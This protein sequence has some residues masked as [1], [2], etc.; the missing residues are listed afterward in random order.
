MCGIAGYVS[1][2]D[3]G[4]ASSWLANAQKA[5][6]HRGPDG[7]AFAFLKE[8]GFVTSN[9]TTERTKVAL[10]HN[11]LSIID[12]SDGGIQ[13]KV[14]QCGR[15]AMTFNGEIY[16][17]RELRRQLEADFGIQM[18]TESDSEVLIEG[19]SAWGCQVLTKLVGMFVF[20][21]VDRLKN[22][23]ILVR[24]LVGIKPL[25]YVET[26]A[27]LAFASE[28]QCLLNWPGVTT[29][30]DPQSTVDYLRFGFSDHRDCK[31]FKDIR[32]VRPGTVETFSLAQG[33]K[34]KSEE[35]WSAKPR[36]ESELSFEDARNRLRELLLESVDYHLR[37][38]VPVA[39]CLSGGIDSSSLVMMMRH[40]G[41][42]SAE[43]HTFSHIAPGTAFDEQRWMDPVQ[44]ASGAIAHKIET[45]ADDLIADLP[46]LIRIQQQPFSTT[47]IYAQ[48]RVM[49]SLHESGLKV[50]LD[51]QGADELFGGYGFHIGARI[52]SLIRGSRFG[53]ALNLARAGGELPGMTF[54]GQ[55][56][57]ALDYV[58]NPQLQIW[59]RRVAGKDLVPSWLNETWIKDN[60]VRVHPY[61]ESRSKF[62]LKSALERGMRGPGLPHLLRYEDQNSMAHSIESRVPYLS[63]PVMEFVLSLPEKYLIS[64][65]AVTKP[66]LREAMRGL[67]PDVVLDRKDKVAF[68]TPEADWIKRLQP[69][70]DDLLSQDHGTYARAFHFDQLRL[71]WNSV[72]AGQASYSPSIWRW[73]NYLAWGQMFGAKLT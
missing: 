35:F 69:F 9:E 11:R 70:V 16:N 49:K 61:R 34:I 21:I 17:Y 46:E 37:S 32:S 47:S 63:Q 36:E 50:T 51:G 13:P 2:Q 29:E 6:H 54:K 58:L 53:S 67:V 45:S 25:L 23:L 60:Q 20:A 73:I 27:G 40:V 12:L 18:K 3:S 62:V 72:K 7:Y 64:D 24:D 19:W 15:F 57:N 71:T 22:E 41:G 44:E 28:I 55:V 10:L 56:A 52:G 65:C 31:I 68:Q 4:V 14:S 43:I 48:Y 26:S 30:L 38:D 8:N 1:I 5:L 66:L 59:A 39:A 33:A 42:P